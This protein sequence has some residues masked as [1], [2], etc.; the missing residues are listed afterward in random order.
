MHIIIKCLQFMVWKCERLESQIQSSSFYSDEGVSWVVECCPQ[1]HCH[2]YL[3][4]TFAQQM[5]SAC[6][7][8]VSARHQALAFCLEKNTKKGLG[9]TYSMQL[10]HSAELANSAQYTYTTGCISHMG[11]YMYLKVPQA[12]LNNGHKVNGEHISLLS[13]NY[14][15]TVFET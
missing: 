13:S 7:H 15:P 4:S 10:Y 5:V 8:V 1:Y 9:H 12:I 6:R 14:Q 11:L 2:Q 3:P